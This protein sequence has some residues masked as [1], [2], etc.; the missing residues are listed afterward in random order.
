MALA[1]LSVMNSAYSNI[2]E[3]IKSDLAL[4]YT[5]SGALMSAYFLGYMMGQIPWGIMADRYGSKPVISLSVLGV[6]LS[7]LTFGFSQGINVAIITRFIAGLLGAGIFVP[8]VRL[9]SSW[10]DQQERGTA[11]GILN[12]GGSLGLITAS[13]AAPYLNLNM[14]WRI[15]LKSIGLF[16]TFSAFIIWVLLKDNVSTSY[17]KIKLSS[18]PF[19]DRRFWV[20]AFSQFIRL[21]S[22]YTFIAWLP[23]VM[24]EE[25]RLN[26][27]MTSTAMSLYNLAGILANPLG[28]AT[29]D[30]VGER[31]VLLAS[32]SLLGVIILVFTGNISVSV[33]YV[34]V[35]LIGWLINFVRSPAFTIIPRVFGTEIA[36]SVSGIHNTF[37]ALGAL[38]IPFTL[39]YVKDY[40][41]SYDIGWLLVSGLAFLSSF[42]LFTLENNDV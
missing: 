25:F 17:G 9:V 33:A 3:T 21:G 23:L 22:Y 5:Q 1:T 34:S 20:L 18:I 37:A 28:G 35:F 11:L 13:W 27:L 38:A 39:G 30:K 31:N 8:V 4:N 36:G 14:G 29:S 7:T 10:F 19:W 41:A 16:G 26:I 12:I 15:T 2:L 6:S 32:F 40:T 24:R 42:I